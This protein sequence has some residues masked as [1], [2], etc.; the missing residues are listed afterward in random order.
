[1]TK[2]IDENGS[3]WGEGNTESA[4]YENAKENYLSKY[5]EEEGNEDIVYTFDAVEDTK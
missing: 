2:I 4:A 3:F 1:M 5:P